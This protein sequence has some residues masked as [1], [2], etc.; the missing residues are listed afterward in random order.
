MSLSPG[1]QVPVGMAKLRSILVPGTPLMFFPMSVHVPLEQ[2]QTS[3]VLSAMSVFPLVQLPEGL[4][5]LVVTLAPLV[6]FVPAGP[7]APV[8]PVAPCSPWAPVAPVAPVA[9]CSPCAPVAPVAPCSPWAPVAPVAPVAPCSPWAPVAPVA[10][11]GP[12][13]PCGPGSPWGPWPGG[14]CAPMMF[15]PVSVQVPLEQLQTS[16]VLRAMSVF[17]LVQ[18]PDGLPELVETLVP[19][20]PLVPFVPFVPGGPWE[21]CES[22]EIFAAPTLQVAGDVVPTAVSLPL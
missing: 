4:P 21:L 10:P 3:S 17:P 14:P 6:P 18:L 19:L 22:H 5:E 8:A 1:L 13:A 15:A 11:C 7:W 12:C 20:V 9:P 2:L 16:S